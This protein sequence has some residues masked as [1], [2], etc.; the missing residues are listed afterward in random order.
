M[1]VWFGDMRSAPD[2]TWE[3][4]KKPSAAISLLES[5]EVDLVSLDH[6]L[7]L[8]PLPGPA[9]STFSGTH[10]LQSSRA[11]LSPFGKAI[12]SL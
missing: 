1:K 4:A 8:Q 11:A 12:T 3:L 7:G 2:E 9:L 5:G 6:D 10:P